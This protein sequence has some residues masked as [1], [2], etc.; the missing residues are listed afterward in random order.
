LTRP[1]RAP[2]IPCTV[3]YS[4]SVQGGASHRMSTC[5]A[6]RC[7]VNREPV[8]L[9][10]TLADTKSS[11]PASKTQSKPAVKPE[12]NVQRKRRAGDATLR[13][14]EWSHESSGQCCAA[15]LECALESRTHPRPTSCLFE[16]A[17]QTTNDFKSTTSTNRISLA[18]R[19]CCDVMVHAPGKQTLLCVGAV[20]CGSSSFLPCICMRPR[21]T[22]NSKQLID[23]CE[24]S[25]DDEDVPGVGVPSCSS[26]LDGHCGSGANGCE[27]CADCVD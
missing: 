5:V 23:A 8:R 1:V 9:A 7:N 3:P 15:G 17:P 21:A 4:Y 13:S 18:C 25:R 12:R 14:I 26:I 20:A 6:S 10:D 22:S 16:L 19:S 24:S 2:V 11:H 27:S